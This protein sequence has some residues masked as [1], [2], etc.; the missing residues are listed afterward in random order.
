M[1]LILRD[2][3]S[4]LQTELVPDFAER[5]ARLGAD[6]EAIRGQISDTENELL[7]NISI[8]YSYAQTDIEFFDGHILDI[9]FGKFFSQSLYNTLYPCK[10]CYIFCVTLGSESERYLNKL[11]SLSP[12]KHFIADA[13]SSAIIEEAANTVEEKIKGTNK[14]TP[15]F[16]VGYGDLDLSLQK[17]ILE[18]TDSSRLLGVSLGKTLLMTPTKTITAVMGIK[19]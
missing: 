16:S 7:K 14:T 15:R 13:L 11:S 10:K 1:S 3:G 8:K 17:D 6:Y 9:G 5:S 18:I 4:I 12:S 2:K 19:I